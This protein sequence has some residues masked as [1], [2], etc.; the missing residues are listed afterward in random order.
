MFNKL[1]VSGYK[2]AG[3][4]ILAAILVGL[5]SYIVMTLF[6]YGS[7]SWIAPIIVS[8]TDKRVLELNAEYAQQQSMRDTLSAQRAQMKTKLRDAERIEQAEQAFQVAVRASL[9]A[10]LDD[11]RITLGKLGA[12]RRSYAA[13]SA[14]ISAANQDFAG[15]SK[16]RMKEMFDARLTTKDE[17]VKGNMELA[18]LANANLGLAER[19]VMLDE[20]VMAARRQTDSLALVDALVR[21]NA[22]GYVPAANVAFDSGDAKGVAPTHEVLAFHREFELSALS[23]KRAK[24]DGESIKQAIAAADATL[25]RYDT[26]LGT[27]KESP[28]LKAADH[29]LTIAFVPY[30]NV[31]SAK[32]G[33]AVYACKGNIIWC[34]RVGT[35]GAA[36]EG[37]VTGAHPLQK[38]DLRGQMVRLE[39]ADIHSAEEPVMHLGRA[40]LFL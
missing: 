16:D 35:V 32:P 27:I 20:Q 19:A 7:S 25:E 8:P 30:T 26:L 15:L 5:G 9:K 18:G 17:V 29:H 3:F 11:R 38:I 23:E 12:L 13:A 31:A 24:E 37:E 4:F 1:I 14:E 10:D 40:P 6:Y 36:L 2:A 21:P 28:Y 34:R 33:T 39:L 22:A